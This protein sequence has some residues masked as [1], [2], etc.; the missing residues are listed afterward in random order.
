MGKTKALIVGVSYYYLPGAS[1][2]PFCKNDINAIS[3]A[4][5]EGLS[6]SLLDITLLGE[7]GIV[8]AS[9]FI[10]ALCMLSS[11]CDDNDTLILY[12][13][14]HGTTSKD[15]HYL[16]FSDKCISTQTII[17][18]LS[19]IKAKSKIIILDCCMAGCFSVNG[20]AVFDIDQTVEDFVGSGYAVFAACNAQQYSYGHPD[21][22]ISLFTDFLCHALTD[23]LIVR[24][25]KKSLH[26]IHKLLFLLLNIWNKNH[27]DKAQN[28]IYRAN[29][30]GT[31]Y[32]EVQDYTPYRIASF[33]DETERYYIT[34][35][36]PL[37][38][39][40][41]K[42]YAVKVILKEPFSFNE[43]AAIN[44]EIVNKVRRVGIFNS[45]IQEAHWSGKPVNI[46][47]CYYALD[48]LDVSNGNYICH[49]TWIDETQDKASWYRIGKGNE[50]ID[51][52]FFS[53]HSYYESLKTF[54][55]DHTA[56][57]E[58]IINSTKTILHRMVTLAEQIISL[59][60]EFN[61]KQLTEEKLVA[62]IESVIPELDKLYFAENNLD[63]PPSELEEWCQCCSN[64]AATIHDFTLF[65]NSKYLSTRTPENRKSCMDITIKR[66]Y[67]DLEKLKRIDKQLKLL[68]ESGS[69]TL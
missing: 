63:F 32:F 39:G 7:A 27:P 30:G 13:S 65:Y 19:T 1:D 40:I 62:S 8:T 51:G 41:A 2:L 38:N 55:L 52:V 37:H 29:L 69:E 20:T 54:I 45:P 11:D 22:P 56:T 46:V 15:Q 31:I 16:V 53:I 12:F 6:V 3:N 47:F 66:Y 64:L 21:K 49:T 33:V 34:S 68:R 61:N 18:Y 25:G 4:F 14:G 17:D 26:D 50:I 35:V 58:Q 42:R 44:Q 23:K 24:S 10:N 60:N 59:F 43:I 36:E 28:P 57:K 48:E 5:T 9:Q 67:Q